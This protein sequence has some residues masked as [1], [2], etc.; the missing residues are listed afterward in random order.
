MQT[1]RPVHYAFTN[2]VNG[3]SGPA[4]TLVLPYENW[5]AFQ[6]PEQTP[7]QLMVEVY[8]QEEATA[9]FEQFTSTFTRTESWVIRVRWDLSVIP[10]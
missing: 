6:G 3:G 1:N 9:A 5:A 8:G 10:E 2:L 4:V 7:F